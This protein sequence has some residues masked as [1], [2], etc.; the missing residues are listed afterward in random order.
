MSKDQVRLEHGL[1][2]VE[3]YKILSRSKMQKSVGFTFLRR[4]HNRESHISTQYDL[5]SIP[6]VQNQ[7]EFWL[8]STHGVLYS[9]GEDSQ[10]YTLDQWLEEY[11]NFEAAKNIP[12]F[13]SFRCCFTICAYFA[14]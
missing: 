2:G 5:I 14:F 4:V 8:F 9:N 7:T 3:C 1:N 13:K 12:Y 11:Q 6:D 10:F